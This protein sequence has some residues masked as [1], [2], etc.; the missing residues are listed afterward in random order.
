MRGHPAR[1][2]VASGISSFHPPDAGSAALLAVTVRNILD[3]AT[4][5]L[6]EGHSQPQVSTP[7]YPSSFYRGG[8]C[9]P[10]TA[11]FSKGHTV[12]CGRGESPSMRQKNVSPAHGH[13]LK[14]TDRPRS[15]HGHKAGCRGPSGQWRAHARLLCTDSFSECSLHT[16]PMPSVVLGTWIE[17][18]TRA[19]TSLSSWR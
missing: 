8:S 13:H 10:V 6:E 14:H 12:S 19:A 9:S 17:P 18:Q 16:C 5:P 2:G 7:G 4:C 1:C 15:G 11:G 3:I